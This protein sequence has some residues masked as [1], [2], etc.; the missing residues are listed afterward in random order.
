VRT[1]ENGSRPS[2][3]AVGFTA[4][5]A[6][7]IADTIRGLFEGLGMPTPTLFA[8]LCNKNTAMKWKRAPGV[9]TS[10]VDRLAKD[11]HR[12]ASATVI[13]QYVSMGATLHHA[14]TMLQDA[15]IPTV[16]TLPG[17]WYHNA[18]PARTEI[19]LD[20]LTSKYSDT[21]K[22]FGHKLAVLYCQQN[23][24]ARIQEKTTE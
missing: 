11:L 1:T 9:R 18:M 17:R 19:N 15:G 2:V 7:P 10:E 4:M 8:V 12:I 20:T 5:S 22:R 23:V 24:A 21:F 16:H 14:S 13:D 3:D 6:V